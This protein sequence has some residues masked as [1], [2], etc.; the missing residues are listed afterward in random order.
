MKNFG[1]YF[2]LTI[3]LLLGVG[4][5]GV[6][7]LFFVP[8]S[9]LFNI[10]YI[11]YNEKTETSFNIKDIH[12]LN[13]NS[14]SYEVKINST[15][16]EDVVVVVYSN[17]FGFVT[18]KNSITNISSSIKDGILALNI[19]EPHGFALPNSSY[20]EIRIP[21]GTN[22]NLG[23]TNKGADTSFISNK[24]NINNFA[25]TTTNGYLTLNNVNING[26]LDLD[27][28]KATFKI[29]ETVNT[30]NSNLKLKVSTGKFYANNSTF[31]NINII[32]TINN[33]W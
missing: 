25:Y 7:Y 5:I 16:N 8:G 32:W 22:L 31:K 19:T 4:C 27:I 33:N 11:S 12:T 10:K 17:S 28:N 2:T 24:I 30:S 13:V 26:N 23:L 21:E 20:V 29:D 18:T 14:R 1:K 3:L 15:E 6:L 9:T